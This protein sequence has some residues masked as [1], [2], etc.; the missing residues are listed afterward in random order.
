V[1]TNCSVSGTTE[2]SVL[3]AH[4]TVTADAWTA[5]GVSGGKRAMGM[6]WQT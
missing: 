1:L 6:R 5:L 4:A 2:R 3:L